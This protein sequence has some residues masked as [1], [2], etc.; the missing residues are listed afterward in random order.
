M[1]IVIEKIL[2]ASPTTA[3]GQ[4]T[5]LS[6]DPKGERITYA[7]SKQSLS[8]RRENINNFTSLAN[9]SSFD[10]LTILP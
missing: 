4:P 7:V 3:R 10:R 6:A 2:A 8:R 9:Q 5:Q 1:S